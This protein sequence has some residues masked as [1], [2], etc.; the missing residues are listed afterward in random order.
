MDYR[1]TKIGVIH[2]THPGL[3]EGEDDMDNITHWAYYKE[4]SQTVT[5]GKEPKE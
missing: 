3:D 1:V 4:P 2:Y 5:L